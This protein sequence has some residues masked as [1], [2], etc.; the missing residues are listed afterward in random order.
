MRHHLLVP[1]CVAAL[2]PV[3]ISDAALAA[4]VDS[5]TGTIDVS[6]NHSSGILPPGTHTLRLGAELAHDPYS[7][8]LR[9]G[10]TVG[11]TLAAVPE[12]DSAGVWAALA[13][14]AAVAASRQ[15]RTK[16]KRPDRDVSKRPGESG[17]G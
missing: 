12:P 6:F 8:A 5:A 15:D 13:G 3:L 4:P 9:G 14:L 11:L 17:F 16:R 2:V 1:S 7:D 10:G